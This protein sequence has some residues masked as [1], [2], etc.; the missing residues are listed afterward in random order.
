MLSCCVVPSGV[1]DHR[2][3][4]KSEEGQEREGNA[5]NISAFVCVFNNIIVPPSS[6]AASLSPSSLLPQL[7]SSEYIYLGLIVKLPASIRNT[8]CY[9][10]VQIFCSVGPVI[11]SIS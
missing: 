4:L 8:L 3:S 1:N 6:A 9:F 5:E 7:P 11:F 2:L 10:I